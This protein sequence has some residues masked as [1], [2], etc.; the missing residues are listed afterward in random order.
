MVRVQRY[1][2]HFLLVAL[3]ALLGACGYSAPVRPAPN[4]NPPSLIGITLNPSTVAGGQS[5]TGTVTI[6]VAAPTGGTLV[7][8]SSNNVSVPTPQTVMVLAGATTATFKIA[9]P[10]VGSPTTVAVFATLNVVLQT[11]LN[12]T[13]VTALSLTGFTLTPSTVPSS[14][15]TQGMITISAPAFAG[16]QSVNLTSVSQLVTVPATVVVPTGATSVLFSVFTAP[17]NAPTS[18]DITAELNGGTKMAT[19]MLTA[20]PA[21][22]S[23]LSMHP[24]PVV[25]GTASTGTLTL[26]LPAPSGGIAI[27]LTSSDTVTLPIPTA[28]TIV[29]IPAGATQAQFMLTPTTVPNTR[30]VQITAT[31][32]PGTLNAVSQSVVLNVVTTAVTVSAL[33][34]S[35]A[36]TT[37]GLQVTGTVSI[38]S[39]APQGGTIVTLSSSNASAATVPATAIVP[40]GSTFVQFPVNTS[41]VTT[42]QMATISAALGTGTPQTSVLTVNPASSVTVSTLTLSPTSVVQGDVSTGTVTL[43]GPAQSGGA[44]VTLSSSDP[45]VSFQPSATSVLVPAGSTSQTFTVCTL[46]SA[47]CPAAA[48]TLPVMATITAALNGSS[49]TAVLSVVAPPTLASFT[50]AASTVTG[51]AST[52]GTLTLSAAAPAGRT[53]TVTL[54]STD[55]SI[56]V[57]PSVAIPSGSTTATFAVT[58]LVVTSQHVATITATLG[59]VM[60]NATLTVTPAAAAVSQIFFNPPSVVGGQASTG[61]VVLNSPAPAGGVTV[62]LSLPAGTTAVTLPVVSIPIAAGATSATFTANSAAVTAATAVHVTATLTSAAQMNTLTVNPATTGTLS[63][64]IIV[65]GET[66]SSDFPVSSGA[67]QA[68]IGGSDSGTLTS[69]NLSTTSG[70]TTSSDTFSTYFGKANLGQVRDIFIDASGNVY[71]CGTTSDSA[72]AVTAGVVQAVYGG[73]LSDAFVAEFDS[74]GHVKFLTYLGGNGDDS[75]NNIFVDSTGNIFVSGRSTSANLMGTTGVVQPALAGGAGGDFFIA[76][77]NPGA[78]TKTWFTFLG[79]MLDDNASGRMAVDSTGNVFI[80]GTSKSIADFPISATQGRPNMTGVIS[81]GVLVE[82]A[83][84]A[85][86]VKHTTFLFG[87]TPPSGMVGTQADASGGLAIDAAGDVYVCGSAA[88]TDFPATAGAFQT[89]FKGNQD[90]YVAKIAANGSIAALTLLGGTGNLQACKGLHLD[91]EGNIIVVTP[92]DAAD[93]PVTGAGIGPLGGPSDFAVTKLTADLST[94]VFSRKIGGSAAENA[95]A[96]RVELDANENIYFSLATSSADFP[97]MTASSFQQFFKGTPGGANNNMAIVKLSADGS[98]ILYAT[99]LGGSGQNSTITLRYKKN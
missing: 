97:G 86:S 72:L 22:L 2:F 3:A 38:S 78:T 82:L 17:V 90:A 99:Y 84:D 7:G 44:V 31:Q 47:S 15:T 32:N 88:A 8:I 75:C 63:E 93:Y 96:T 58:T 66:T 56:Q 41:A 60:L 27:T 11:T 61:T 98:S 23:G 52:T 92:T 53:T 4:P 35:S 76:K 45:T 48:G 51:G 81:F 83:A 25:G 74:T 69:I 87:R 65:G 49:K 37:G 91:S 64:Q 30:R 18:V 21:L 36:S 79:G 50:L 16:G 54:T 59:S 20:P 80:T 28:T 43:S 77:L 19:L 67:L 70:T 33:N 46:Q 71:A 40:S 24:N 39:A 85:T 5:T 62:T 94:L 42:V 57:P 73:G 13:P 95:D 9:T 10:Q 68:T 29:T 14:T 6:S 55:P 34:L 1:A 12:I 89:V 26:T